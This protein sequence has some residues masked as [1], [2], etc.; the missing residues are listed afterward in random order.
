MKQVHDWYY[1][2]GPITATDLLEPIAGL[3]V[4]TGYIWLPGVAEKAEYAYLPAIKRLGIAWGADASW[5]D[6]PDL[7]Q[8]IE[9]W[10]TDCDE[11]DARN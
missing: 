11:W 8:G 4:E 2:E 1:E 3:P 6:V 9:M 7:E 10:W 5:A